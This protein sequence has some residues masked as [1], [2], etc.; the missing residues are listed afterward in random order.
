M[1]QLNGL[2]TTELWIFQSELGI[3]FFWLGFEFLLP[4]KSSLWQLSEL[5]WREFTGLG[6]RF[7]NVTHWKPAVFHQVP[8]GSSSQHIFFP[9]DV[10]KVNL[11]RQRW[12][13][14][15]TLDSF[16]MSIWG[17]AHRRRLEYSLEMF[18]SSEY[19]VYHIQ[20]RAI[21][22]V[23][24][25]WGFLLVGSDTRRATKLLSGVKRKHL[26]SQ[27]KPSLSFFVAKPR[28][29]SVLSSAA[30]RLTVASGTFSSS[31]SSSVVFEDSFAAVASCFCDN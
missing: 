26:S 25:G 4:L 5:K 15:N 14:P 8:S 6:I 11:T 24:V 21:R 23:S 2:I 3:L 12:R 9:P 29:N 1:I 22:S 20:G 7:I 30:A 16:H 13:F 17:R 31:W 27:E 18:I 10:P 28:S 19:S